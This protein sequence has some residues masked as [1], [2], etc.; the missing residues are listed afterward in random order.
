VETTAM[1]PVVY[2]WAG[3][4]VSDDGH[5][6]CQGALEV[7]SNSKDR[8]IANHRFAGITHIQDSVAWTIQLSYSSGPSPSLDEDLV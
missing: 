6:P 2:R 4:L 1:S 5:V 3:N 8:G 7:G